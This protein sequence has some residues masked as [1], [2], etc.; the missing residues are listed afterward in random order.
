MWEQAKFAYFIASLCYNP[1]HSTWPYE[2][3]EVESSQRR[4]DE[5]KILGKDRL[6]GFYLHWKKEIHVTKTI[7]ALSQIN[8]SL[9][10]LETWLRST[11]HMRV[12]AHRN[13]CSE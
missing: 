4:R 10:H 3:S 11:V 8:L 6:S 7:S 13:K 2:Q 1:H 9:H 12:V 5:V